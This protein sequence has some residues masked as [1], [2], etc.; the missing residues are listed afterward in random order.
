MPATVGELLT[1]AAD[2]VQAFSDHALRNADLPMATTLRAWR[3]FEHR[4]CSALAVTLGPRVPNHPVD[5]AVSRWVQP[6]LPRPGLTSTDAPAAS[7]LLRA[8]GLV[9]AAGDLITQVDAPAEEAQ[10]AAARMASIVATAAYAFVV[11]GGRQTYTPSQDLAP[12]VGA[13][14]AA[15]R[16]V[17]AHSGLSTRSPLDDVIAEPTSIVYGAGSRLAVAALRLRR[18]CMD[19]DPCS[20]VFILSAVTSGRLVITAWQLLDAAQQ[21]GLVTDPPGTSSRE[22][23]RQA[24]L[25]WRDVAHHW[26]DHVVPGRR[27]E[28]VRAAAAELSNA[29]DALDPTDLATKPGGRAALHEAVAGVARG[30]E[31][32]RTLQEHHGQLVDHLANAGLIFVPARSLQPHLERLQEV[33]RGGFVPAQGDAKLMLASH[34]AAAV[35]GTQ[36]AQLC[37]GAANSQLSKSTAVRVHSARE[38]TA[39]RLRNT[40]SQRSQRM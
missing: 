2:E 13:Q 9:G 26:R 28:S 32:V 35:R 36:S 4:C 37:L 10:G 18:E 11:T 6:Q 27:P 38:S 12:I 1:L 15:S 39:V 22:T 33:L 14:A 17:D 40:M 34:A 20:E 3:T 29:C 23:L 16:V 19:A 25:A 31:H 30:L 7:H 8:A 21:A 24:A 5:A